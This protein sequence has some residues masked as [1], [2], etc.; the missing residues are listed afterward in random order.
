[1]APFDGS[2]TI[3]YSL[4][5]HAEGRPGRVHMTEQ[6]DNGATTSSTDINASIKQREARRKF[7]TRLTALKSTAGCSERLYYGTTWNGIFR[8]FRSFETATQVAQ[9]RF[10]L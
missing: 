8:M 1:M 2:H 5:L 6:T 9:L 7:T 4:R 10:T 3:W